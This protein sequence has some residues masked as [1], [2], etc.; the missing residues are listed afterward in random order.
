MILKPMTYNELFPL[1][2]ECLYKEPWRQLDA[3]RVCFSH[4]FELDISRK[5]F[6]KLLGQL[7]DVL[8]MHFAL[9]ESHASEDPALVASHL[10]RESDELVA[11][12]ETLYREIC[13]IVDVAEKRFYC[14]E[15]RGLR[16]RLLPE[17]HRFYLHL[18]I[19]KHVRTS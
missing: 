17:L 15:L 19:T 14:K 2:Y 1:E 9:E 5:R 13:A 8:G 12:H 11:E 4:T 18:S 6:V 7:R 16:R 10:A 3:L